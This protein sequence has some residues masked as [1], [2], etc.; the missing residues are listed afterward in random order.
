LVGVLSEMELNTIF[1]ISQKR[2]SVG[3]YLS[4]I[5]NDKPYLKVGDTY[6]PKKRSESVF[7]DEIRGNYW[8]AWAES[9]KFYCEYDAGHFATDLRIIEIS[10]EDFSLLKAGK[11]TDTDLSRKYGK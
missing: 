3:L 10:K 2:S 1:A 11:I 6:Y 9:S 7:D 5:M 8:R 4:N